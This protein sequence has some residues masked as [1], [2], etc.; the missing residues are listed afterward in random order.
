MVLEDT[1]HATLDKINHHYHPVTN[2]E[3]QSSDFP[4]SH[5]GTIV[6]QTLQV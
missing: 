3:A 4:V 2:P 5:N 6:E 1:L